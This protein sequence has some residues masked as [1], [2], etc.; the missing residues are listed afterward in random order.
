VHQ[1]QEAQLVHAEEVFNK[2]VDNLQTRDRIIDKENNTLRAK[3]VVQFHG[4]LKPKKTKQH[5]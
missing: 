3:V 5:F 2:L 4:C 1:A